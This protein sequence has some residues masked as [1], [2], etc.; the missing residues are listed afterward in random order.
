[1]NKLKFVLLHTLYDLA[2]DHALSLLCLYV[3]QVSQVM[4]DSA[5]ENDTD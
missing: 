1:M 5:L 2:W 3:S 4:Y